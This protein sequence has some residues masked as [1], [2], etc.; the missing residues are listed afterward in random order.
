[1]TSDRWLDAMLI[2]TVSLVAATAGYTT[3]DRTTD[4]GP[5]IGPDEVVVDKS[6]ALSQKN[7]L[8]EAQR[9]PNGTVRF[10]CAETTC[11][12]TV[13]VDRFHDFGMLKAVVHEES[14]VI[15]QA[16]MHPGDSLRGYYDLPENATLT[17][18]V[19]VRDETGYWW[20]KSYSLSFQATGDGE[21][22]LS[23]DAL[24]VYS[25]VNEE[26]FFGGPPANATEGGVG[27]GE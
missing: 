8:T 13:D 6:E 26:Y 4:D 11:N 21:S 1:M 16:Y 15:L 25:I 19:P 18:A 27:G 2:I 22:E 10:D 12:V 5:D 20:R 3:G 17:L 23:F 14:D 7:G 9:G 24:V